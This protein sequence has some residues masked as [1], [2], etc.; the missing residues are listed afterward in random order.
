MNKKETWKANRGASFLNEAAM[1]AQRE[2][3]TWYQRPSPFSA[4]PLEGPCINHS[5]P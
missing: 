3:T 4:L 5:N 1:A 2:P